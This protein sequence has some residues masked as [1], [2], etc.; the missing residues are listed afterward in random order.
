MKRSKS[1][2]MTCIH[3]LGSSVVDYVVYDIF[4]Y[5][6]IVNFGILN[7]HVLDSN[8][9]PITLTLNFGMH[10]SPIEENFDNQKYLIFTKNKVDLYQKQG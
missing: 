3:G 4:I 2:Q 1:N 5:N 7:K 10:K 6:Q 8:H 9:R